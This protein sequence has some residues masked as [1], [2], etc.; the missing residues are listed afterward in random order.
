MS[1]ADN[2]GDEL[3]P[4]EEQDLRRLAGFMAPASAKYDVPGADDE[5]IFADM[6][7]LPR[8]RQERRTRGAVVSRRVV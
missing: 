6:V 8:A 7:R 2:P 4:K 1:V 5:A 3:T